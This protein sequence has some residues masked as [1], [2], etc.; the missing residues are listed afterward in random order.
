MECPNCGAWGPGDPSTGYDVDELCP[1]CADEGWTL[2]AQ[3]QLVEP[4]DLSALPPL[5]ML[6]AQPRPTTIA[7][8]AERWPR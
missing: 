3:G 1:R 5:R 6:R 8:R 2:T 7:L 4:L